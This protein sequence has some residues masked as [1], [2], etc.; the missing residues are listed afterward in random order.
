MD[1]SEI[2]RKLLSNFNSWKYLSLRVRAEVCLEAKRVNGRDE[3]LDTYKKEVFLKKHIMWE[4]AQFYLYGVERRPRDGCVLCDVSP[5]A[6]QDG[7]HG[8]DAVGGGLIGKK[9][10]K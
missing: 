4:R 1:E 10:E 3:R 9:E 5:A 8:G 2:I 7:V 6:G